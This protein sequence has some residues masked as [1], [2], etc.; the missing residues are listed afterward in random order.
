MYTEIRLLELDQWNLKAVFKV[1]STIGELRGKSLD[2]RKR[3][4]YFEIPILK[5][6]NK[7]LHS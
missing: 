6:K 5:I 3:I 4:K 7:N 1:D 2:R